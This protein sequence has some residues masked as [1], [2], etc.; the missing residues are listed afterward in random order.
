MRLRQ[1]AAVSIAAFCVRAAPA[2]ADHPSPTSYGVPALEEARW[3]ASMRVAALDGD[4]FE[5]SAALMVGGRLFPIPVSFFAAVPLRLGSSGH[6]HVDRFAPPSAH[7]GATFGVGDLFA[8]LSTGFESGFGSAQIFGGVHFPT[9]TLQRRIGRSPFDAEL[10]VALRA[11]VPYAPIRLVGTF[12]Y[13]GSDGGGNQAGARTTIDLWNVPQLY[14]NEN[15]LLGLRLGWRLLHE[16][17]ERHGGDIVSGTASW[18]V[19]A[20]LGPELRVGDFDIAGVFWLPTFARRGALAHRL[21]WGLDITAS[22]S[23]GSA[24]ESSSDAH[25]HDEHP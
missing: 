20:G 3:F 13:N 23:F 4:R 16:S 19:L 14:R 25:S 7:P 24:E 17:A 8:G 5:G 2:L 21:S 12:R 11:S 1:I 15:V 6:V 10:G 22:V 18:N 9:D